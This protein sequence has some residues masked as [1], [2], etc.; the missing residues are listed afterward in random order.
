MVVT[1]RSGRGGNA[2]TSSQRQ[3]VEDYQVVKE[4]EVP[5]NIVQPNEEVRI[6]TDDSV[7]DTQEE[8]SIRG[9]FSLKQ[10]AIQSRSQGRHQFRDEPSSSHSTSKGSESASQASESSA[11]PVPEAQ[12][13]TPVH[14]IT[15]DGRGGDATTTRVEPR[16][17]DTKVKP[18]KPFDSCSLMDARNP[19]KKVQPP[20]T[21]RRSNEPEVVVS[22]TVDV[23]STSAQP[24]SSAT[25]MPLPSSTAP[26]T[27][28]AIAPATASAL[29][30]VSIPTSPLS[31]LRVS[32]TLA[33]LNN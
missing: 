1:T 13:P 6:D 17:F 12:V 26:P 8:G 32:Q 24:S 7:E 25:A 2:P 15:D 28:H 29:R 14:D 33:S 21:T 3:L 5:N 10:P 16:D 19:K 27:A 11:T 22:E 23:P 4:E 18:K 30:P 20:T 31:T 9:H